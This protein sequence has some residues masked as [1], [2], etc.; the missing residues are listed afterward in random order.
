MVGLLD[1]VIADPVANPDADS[2]PM[3]HMK[4][5]HT[6]FIWFSPHVVNEDFDA[7]TQFTGA[8]SRRIR[9]TRHNF[10]RITNFV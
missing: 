1:V 4:V 3:T 2:A 7:G 5:I 8:L 9:L 10:L 6:P